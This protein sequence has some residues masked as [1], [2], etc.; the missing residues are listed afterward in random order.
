MCDRV[1]GNER[2][3]E[4]YYARVVTALKRGYG[5]RLSILGPGSQ[6]LTRCR[7]SLEVPNSV[8]LE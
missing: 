2:S 4:C 7:Y 1:I 5:K 3:I 6:N 8:A